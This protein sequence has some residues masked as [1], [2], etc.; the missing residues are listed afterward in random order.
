[1][2]GTKKTREG[3]G[4]VGNVRATGKKQITSYEAEARLATVILNCSLRKEIDRNAETSERWNVGNFGT[5]ETSE[6]QE[7]NKS[8]RTK[9]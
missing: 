7:R 8:L 5:S 9:R 1:M 3:S 6:P 4:N 2:T